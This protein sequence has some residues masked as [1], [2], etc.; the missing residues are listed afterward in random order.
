MIKVDVEWAEYDLFEGGKE[1]FKI[2]KS[3]YM[4]IEAECGKRN[5]NGLYEI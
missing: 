4:Y 2:H 1:F 5:G 3:E